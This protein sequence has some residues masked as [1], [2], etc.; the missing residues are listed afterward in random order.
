MEESTSNMDN[1]DHEQE[2]CE[3]NQPSN[4]YEFLVRKDEY[5]VDGK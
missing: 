2:S 5:S 4:L 1:Y 3:N